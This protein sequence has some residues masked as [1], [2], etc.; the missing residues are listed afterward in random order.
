MTIF[1]KAERRKA[2]LRLAIDGP[3]GSGKTLSS[4]LIANGITGDWSKVAV[5]DTERGSA[6]L[7]VGTKIP[8]STDTIGE[9]MVASLEPPYSPDR[10]VEM[11]AAAEQVGA[12]VLI[13]DSLSHAWSGVG[14]VLDMHNKATQ[15][16]RSKNSYT[17]WRDVTP[18]HNELIDRIIGSPM[19]VIC[20][21]RT[22]TAYDMEEDD[23]GR[24]KPVKVGM[25][26]EQREGTE[27]EFTAVLDL[28]V[29]SH[30]AVA[31]K[32]RTQLFDGKPH[33]PGVDTGRRLRDW[34]EAGI[35]P[36]EE[37]KAELANALDVDELREIAGKWKSDA[38]RDGWLA[39]LEGWFRSRQAEILDSDGADDGGG[40]PPGDTGGP[41]SESS[42]MREA[43]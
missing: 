22:K 26:P 12:E 38:K 43:S 7:Y 4:L 39:D 20:T 9:Y 28:A 19:H 30:I 6:D 14:G 24:K 40:L 33:L 31:G 23:K 17:A 11:I 34:L 41:S 29:D 37:C 35:D 36:V 32:D 2:K 8:G 21:M 18:A 15:A 3:S 16:S 5:I 1:R 25:K 42:N 27:Y 13:I 10:Y